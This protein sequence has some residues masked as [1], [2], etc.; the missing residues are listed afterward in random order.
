MSRYRTA[1]ARER[2]E[3]AARV[4]AGGQQEQRRPP[5][6]V[7]GREYPACRHC[8]AACLPPR[9]TFC[10]GSLAGVSRAG[11]V[12]KPGKGCVHEWAIRSWPQYARKLVFARDGGVCA[13][14][15][16]NTMMLAAAFN[17]MQRASPGWCKAT[18]PL[19][20]TAVEAIGYAARDLTRLSLWEADHVVPVVE[21]GGEAGLDGLRTL[22]LACHRVETAALAKRRAARRKAVAALQAAIARDAPDA[23]VHQLAQVLDALQRGAA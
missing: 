6:V 8:G 3:A 15:G 23:E 21:G 16:V 14:C 1:A 4:A 18:E 7:D 5:V 12:S 22:C 11:H 9:R 17:T 19:V 2:A 20:V 13:K 10:G